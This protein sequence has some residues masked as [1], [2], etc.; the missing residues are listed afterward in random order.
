MENEIKASKDATV[1]AVH[2]AQ[3]NTVNTGDL[4]VSLS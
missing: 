4:L 1:A 2:V 3:G